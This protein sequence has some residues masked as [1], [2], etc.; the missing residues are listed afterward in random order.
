MEKDKCNRI[1]EQGRKKSGRRFERVKQLKEWLKQ[2]DWRRWS[3]RGRLRE[4]TKRDDLK[5][6]RVEKNEK[7][8]QSGDMRYDHKEIW[9]G[10]KVKHWKREKEG[11]REHEI[12]SDMIHFSW[13]RPKHSQLTHYSL[14]ASPS[15]WPWAIRNWHAGAVHFTWLLLQQLLQIH[16]EG[17]IKCVW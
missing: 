10:E 11:S 8:P 17:N 5:P 12:A 3:C 1:K 9:R 4:E 7:R 14:P 15:L 6:E 13:V 16:F 2:R